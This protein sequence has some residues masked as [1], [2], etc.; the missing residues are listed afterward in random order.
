MLV[1]SVKWRPLRYK[2]ARPEAEDEDITV[3][4]WTGGDDLRA[5]RHSR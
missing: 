5:H 4:G 3:D 1:T 2:N